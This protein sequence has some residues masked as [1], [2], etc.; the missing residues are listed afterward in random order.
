MK[1]GKLTFRRP[2]LALRANKGCKYVIAREATT[3]ELWFVWI[4]P[5]G[6]MGGRLLDG[7]ETG[8]STSPFDTWVAAGRLPEDARTV[9]VGAGDLRCTVKVRAGVW[10][11]AIPWGNLDLEVDFR[12]LDREGSIVSQVEETLHRVVPLR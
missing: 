2:L 4:D 1:F 3:R 9:D 6:A 7:A 5:D 10:L 11:A 8:A 12:F